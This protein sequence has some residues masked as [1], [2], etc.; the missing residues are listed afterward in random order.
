V[1]G[2][3]SVQG[4]VKLYGLDGFPFLPPL[5]S[6]P[7]NV[8]TPNTTFAGAAGVNVTSIAASWTAGTAFV[9]GLPGTDPTATAMG[10]NGLTPGGQGTLVLVTPIKLLTNAVGTVAGFGTLTLTYVP[11]PGTLALLGLGI[12]ALAATGRRRL[13]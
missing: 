13:V 3:L 10:S 2:N 11:E 7:L 5:L 6:I 1:G 12:A 8:G 9:S 4:A